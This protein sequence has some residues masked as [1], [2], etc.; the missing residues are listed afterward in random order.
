LVPIGRPARIAAPRS[1]LHRLRFKP[2]R[3]SVWLAPSFSKPPRPGRCTFERFISDP[4]ERLR[5]TVFV[6]L[7]RQ[8][9][10]G[11]PLPHPFGASPSTR[12]RAPSPTATRTF[13]RSLHAA[14]RGFPPPPSARVAPASRFRAFNQHAATDPA[15]AQ[16]HCSDRL[17]SLHRSSVKVRRL[18]PRANQSHARHADATGTPSWTASPRPLSRVI[19]R[20]G[21]SPFFVPPAEILPPR[22]KVF[23][24]LEKITQ[25]VG[26]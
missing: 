11:H 23:G 25:G 3:L 14:P 8:P 15:Q 13:C 9:P 10:K 18:S 26:G 24:R 7:V 20:N 2:R 5:L 16:S 21:Q 1:G 17:G 6:V 4:N 22:F 19:G 12:C